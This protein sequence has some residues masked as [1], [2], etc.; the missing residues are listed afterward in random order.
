M[1]H[2]VSELR[3]FIVDTYLFGEE[4]TTFTLT[5]DDSFQDRGVIDSTGVLELIGHLQDT[6]GIVVSDDEIVPDNLDSLSRVARFVSQKLSER[7]A[8]AHAG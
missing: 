4:P 8:V 3:K 6:Y 2:L 1:P 5:N 7:P